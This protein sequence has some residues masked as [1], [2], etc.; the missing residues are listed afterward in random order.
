MINKNTIRNLILTSIS[1]LGMQ[2]VCAQQD[3]Q[4]TQYMY[5]PAVINPAYAGS[6]SNLQIFGLYRTQWVGLEGA[7]KTAHIS[8]TTP[9]TDNGLGL[10]VH[11]KNDHLGVMDENSLS[12]DLAYTV[13]LNYQYKLAFG[14]KG[15]GHF[16]MWIIINSTST[17]EQILFQNRI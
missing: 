15:A 11:F 17:M 4:Y 7:P 9:L 3:P 14:L 8:V 10:G 6:V 2:Q 1:V 13:N 16:W 5:N 12:I